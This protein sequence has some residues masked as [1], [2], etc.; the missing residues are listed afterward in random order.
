MY[1]FESP[2]QNLLNRE[3]FVY[4]CVCTIYFSVYGSFYMLYTV[5]ASKP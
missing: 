4:V 2:K 5:G 3:Q 1:L